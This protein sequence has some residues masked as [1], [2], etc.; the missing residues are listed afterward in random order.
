MA[1]DTELADRIRFLIG[2]GPSV[3]EKR[4]FGGLAFLSKRAGH[5]ASQPTAGRE[6]WST[7]PSPYARASMRSSKNGVMS[8]VDSGSPSPGQTKRAGK[9]NFLAGTA[10]AA[11]V[12]RTFE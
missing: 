10:E 5:V 8:A 4:M 7:E 1:Y 3:T 9:R 11:V 6:M 2:I 12:D